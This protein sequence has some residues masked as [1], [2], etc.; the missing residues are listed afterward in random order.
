MH[1]LLLDSVNKR[2]ISDVPLGVLLSGGIDSSLITALASKSSNTPINTVNISFKDSKVD[3]SPYADITAKHCKTNHIK[4]QVSLDDLYERFKKQIEIF[5]DLST[6]DSGLF[7][8]MLLTQKVRE[9]G[10]KVDTVRIND[11]IWLYYSQN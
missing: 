6:V 9:E 1:K 7:S 3:E 2:L 4:L 5:D 10:L 11:E 8:T